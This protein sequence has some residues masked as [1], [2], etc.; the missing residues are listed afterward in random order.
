MRGAGNAGGSRVSCRG[1]ELCSSHNEGFICNPL[2]ACALTPRYTHET[3]PHR[4]TNS[5]RHSQTQSKTHPH[6]MPIRHS[7]TKPGETHPPRRA[8]S[9]THTHT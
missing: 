1:P 8:Q 5:D 3:P 7:Q 2:K 9:H 4:Y 6:T